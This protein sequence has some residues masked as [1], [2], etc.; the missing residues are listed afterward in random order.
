MYSNLTAQQEVLERMEGISDYLLIKIE[1]Q[2]CYSQT[3]VNYRG[4][5]VYIVAEQASTLYA[6]SNLRRINL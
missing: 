6:E 1:F 3:V 2:N 4:K 5:T